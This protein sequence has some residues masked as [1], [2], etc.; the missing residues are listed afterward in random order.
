MDVSCR[1]EEGRVGALG[2]SGSRRLD[3][4]QLPG[5]RAQ[6]VLGVAVVTERLV[7]RR[8]PQEEGARG[9][10]RG[11]RLG[12]CRTEPAGESDHEREIRDHD[13]N[14]EEIERGSRLE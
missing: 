12:P 9:A 14:E 6:G 8:D 1:L 10:A 4:E 2:A 7:D 13:L 11:S 3:T 5:P